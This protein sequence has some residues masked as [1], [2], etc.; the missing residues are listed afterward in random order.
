[1][2]LMSRH[3][4]YY[5]L[6]KPFMKNEPCGDLGYLHENK[7]SLFFA[8][9]D[10]AGHGDSAHQFAVV[11][12]NYFAKNHQNDL[13]DIMNNLHALLR[14]SRGAVGVAG[15]LD[16]KTGAV[17]YVGVG[18]I[19]IRIFGKKNRRPISNE[20]IIGYVIPTPKIERL[21]L[22]AGDVL[23]LYTD[24]IRDHFNANEC[25][26][27]LFKKNAKQIAGGIMKHFNKGNDDAAC[28]AIRYKND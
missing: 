22:S 18:N 16:K 13:L 2:G 27:D 11:I 25:P 12:K 3:V 21:Q 9:A 1:M 28:I 5:F 17:E 23:L 15:L 26:E 4:D 24:G 20:G 7:E 14:G 6:K 19:S 8:I 10:V